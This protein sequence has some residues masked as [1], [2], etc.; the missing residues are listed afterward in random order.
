METRAAA[1]ERIPGSL[2]WCT[3]CLRDI[4]RSTVWLSGDMHD[5]RH[6]CYACAPDNAIRL[7]DLARPP[8]EKR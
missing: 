7:K 2:F 3:V 4:T 5:G 6:F 1:A 8:K